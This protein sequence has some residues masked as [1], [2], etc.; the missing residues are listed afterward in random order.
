MDALS[1]RFRRPMGRKRLKF[2]PAR[3][4][5]YS[6]PKSWSFRTV[7][8]TFAWPSGSQ[9]SIGYRMRKMLA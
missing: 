2:L 3:S 5:R 7:C 9:I 1:G 4:L 8:K 6:R